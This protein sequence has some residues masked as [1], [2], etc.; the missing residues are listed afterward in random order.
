MDEDILALGGSGSHRLTQEICYY[1]GIPVGKGETMK[2]SKGPFLSE[3]SKMSEAETSIWFSQPST[4][5]TTIS[6]NSSSGSTHSSVRV[7]SQLPLP[8]PISATPKAT[9]KTNPAFQSGPVSVQM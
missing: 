2:F 5:R 4:R 3:F 6:W 8:C 1:L 9:I 7:H